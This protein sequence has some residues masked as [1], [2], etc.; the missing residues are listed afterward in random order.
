MEVMIDSGVCKKPHYYYN[1]RY[2]QLNY[3]KN[4]T[5]CRK[6]INKS[7]TELEN[8]NELITPLIKNGQPLGHI[9][10]SHAQKIA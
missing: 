10:A 9:Y 3:S 7:P 1:A 8:L 5:D 4:L 6:G 2:A